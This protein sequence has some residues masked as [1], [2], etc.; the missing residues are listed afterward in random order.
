MRGSL[1]SPVELPRSDVA[2]RVVLLSV[3]K[4]VLEEVARYTD[5]DPPA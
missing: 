1:I 5:I 3:S 4:S 2:L